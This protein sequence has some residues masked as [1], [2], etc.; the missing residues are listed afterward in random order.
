M[1]FVPSFKE[2]NDLI[3]LQLSDQESETEKR[4]ERSEV[5]TSILAK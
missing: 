4:S 5:G 1:L 3:I 2:K